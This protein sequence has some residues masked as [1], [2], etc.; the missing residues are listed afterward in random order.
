[1]PGVSVTIDLRPGGSLS[2]P[3]TSGGSHFVFGADLPGTVNAA[4]RHTVLGG[5]AL[6]PI[7]LGDFHKSWVGAC[8]DCRF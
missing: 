5:I 4:G 7:G 6:I 8:S 2:L 3:A 1:M